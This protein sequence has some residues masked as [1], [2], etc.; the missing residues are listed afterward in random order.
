MGADAKM[1]GK[2]KKFGR[3]GVEGHGQN[4]EVSHEIQESPVPKA[5]EKAK[6]KKEVS[7]QVK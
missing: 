7:K 4:C 6:W 5:A 1:L 3:C 2:V